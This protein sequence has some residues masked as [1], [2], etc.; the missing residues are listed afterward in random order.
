MKTILST[1][2]FLGRPGVL[3]WTFLALLVVMTLYPTHDL[4]MA[5]TRIVYQAHNQGWSRE[6]FWAEPAY[7]WAKIIAGLIAVSALAWAVRDWRAGNRERAKIMGAALLSMILGLLGVGLMKD[8]SGVACPWSIA[9]FSQSSKAVLNN[10]FAWLFSS[11]AISQGHCW[12]S[13]HAGSGFALIGFYFAARRIAPR[14]A[15]A[16]LVFVMTFGILCSAARI[17]QGAHFFSHCLATFLFDWVVAAAVFAFVDGKTT[18]TKKTATVAQAALM[19]AGV[20]TVAAAPFFARLLSMGTVSAFWTALGMT[21][22]LFCLYVA[23]LY[24][25]VYLLPKRGWRIFLMVLGTTAAGGIAFEVLYGTVITSDM[26]RNALATDAREVSELVGMRLISTGILFALPSWF[27]ALMTPSIVKT[28]VTL[29][30]FVSATAVSFISLG[31]CLGIIVSQMGTTAT[32]IRMDKQARSFIV[33]VSIYYGLARTMMHDASP[34]KSERKVIDP[35]PVLAAGAA[36]QTRPLL[37]V[38]VA[39]ETA[40]VANWGLA[41]YERD[42]TP[43]LKSRQVAAFND[44][45]ACGTSTDVSLPCMFSRVGRADYDRK[46]ILSEESVLSVIRRAGVDVRWADNQSGCKG[47]CTPEMMEKVTGDEALCPDGY[48]YDAALIHNVDAAIVKAKSQPRQ[49][50]V[51]HMMGSHGPSY[52]K[53]VPEAMKNYGEGC[54]TE[55][56]GSCTPQAVRDSYDDS[57]AYTDWVLAQMIDGLKAAK[58]VDTVL[59]YVSDHGES[60]G[61]KGMWLH[62]APYWAGVDEQMKVPMVMWMSEGA[63]QRFGIT[64]QSLAALATKPATHDNLADTLL[65]LSEVQSTIYRSDR[66]LTVLARKENLGR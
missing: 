31:A 17:L 44:V 19:S 45:T 11:S 14:Y 22:L 41:G 10:P 6:W 56:L 61:E 50:L 63:Y 38:M 1:S 40:R 43:Q 48:C 65:G 62:G 51:L 59:L 15:K 3:T 29:K 58:D 35:K 47:A 2:R 8:T 36:L 16:V 9:E 60:L 23:I 66:D 20:L 37:V 21:M 4:D 52:Y 33:P 42:T 53:R 27:V 24:P 18:E 28:Q 34:D 5:L 57:I 7:R 54:R 12:P 49:L 13:G 30:S 64:P 55:N 46:K 26:I 39:G 25:V 32:F